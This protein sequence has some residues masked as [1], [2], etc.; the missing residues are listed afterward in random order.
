MLAKTLLIASFAV[1]AL[2]C[3][4]DHVS[5]QSSGAA[6]A[7]KKQPSPFSVYDKSPAACSVMGPC[8]KCDCPSSAKVAPESKTTAQPPYA[9]EKSSRSRKKKRAARS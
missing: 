3:T 5:A 8:G 9:G 7:P 6:A 1:T 2:V 4:S